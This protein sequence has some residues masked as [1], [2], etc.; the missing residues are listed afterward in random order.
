VVNGVKRYNFDF[1]DIPQPIFP[2]LN[3]KPTNRQFA[4]FQGGAITN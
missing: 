4:G 3:G 1:T 2:A